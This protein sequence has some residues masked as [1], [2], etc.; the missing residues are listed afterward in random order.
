VRIEL[1]VLRHELEV[2][3]RQVGGDVVVR[4]GDRLG[5]LLELQPPVRRRR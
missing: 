2:L 1:M 5:P 4:P 3:R